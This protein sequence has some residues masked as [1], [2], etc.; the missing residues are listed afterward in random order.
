MNLYSLVSRL[1]CL[2]SFAVAAD[3]ASLPYVKPEILDDD[4]DQV[5]Q[6]EQA[7][8]PILEQMGVN[9]IPNDVL[10]DR[11]KNFKIITGPNLG[12]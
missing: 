5:L 6:L 9:F 8:H 3:S 4:E 11:K 2:V 10:L 12:R 7:R 1:D